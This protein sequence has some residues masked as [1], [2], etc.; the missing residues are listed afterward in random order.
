MIV[1]SFAGACGGAVTGGIGRR[2]RALTRDGA[3]DGV[4]FG[5][6]AA[7]AP[8]RARFRRRLSARPQPAFHAAPRYN[9]RPARQPAPLP[10]PRAAN[11]TPAAA[12]ERRG[13]TC[14]RTPTILLPTDSLATISLA[15]VML[16][17]AG[18]NWVSGDRFFDREGDIEALAERARDG[19]HTLLTAQ[20]RM[21]KTSLIREVLRRLG[22]AGE[23]T[24]VFVDL[25][26]AL[27][28]QDAIAELASR[29]RPIAPLW[30]RVKAAFERLPSIGD[31]I[32]EVQASELRV[33]L[34]A[35]IDPGNWQYRGDRIFE[36]LA[37]HDPPV[38]LAIDELP[39]F[40]NRLLLGHGRSITPE[41][42]SSADEFMSFLRKNGQEYNGRPCLMVSGSI[43]LAPILRRA[44]LSATAN[45]F[46]PYE[47]KPWSIQTSFRCLRALA[48]T[49][50][51]DLP[52]P[53]CR[54]MCDR[55]RSC[56]PHHIQ[57]FFDS[58]HMYLRENDRK[59]A[60]LDDVGYVYERRMLGVASQL[61]M[62]HYEQ[63]LKAVFDDTGYRT[64]LEI[65]TYASVHGGR[66]SDGV[67]KQYSDYFSSQP[68]TDKTA[69]AEN[70]ANV[71]DILKHDGYLSRES[72][73]QYRFVSGLLE[74]WW[75]NRYEAQFVPA[76]KL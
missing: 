13:L 21:G 62:D 33:K 42:R 31:I 63:R 76:Y 20:R 17:K 46:S 5:R 44:G 28:A 66:I 19:A 72:G 55:L 61:D 6:R 14:R 52:P 49:Y 70:I 59:I 45:I 23:F 54:A 75:R 69:A 73:G 40:V 27:D 60:K 37:E 36:H 24:P 1:A 35:G 47:L 68:K 32:D 9:R 58:M 8:D 26:R 41:R 30:N 65:L 71:L 12:A 50:T 22:D 34:R 7:P 2:A 74:D 11:R 57:R 4:R 38:V 15:G 39:L 16:R 3:A 48:Q 51:I 56:V 67:V 25:E 64:A 10:L 29:C 18:G 53:I 43:G